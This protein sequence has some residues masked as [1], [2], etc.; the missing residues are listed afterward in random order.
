MTNK[1]RHDKERIIVRDHVSRQLVMSLSL[2]EVSRNLTYE[3]FDDKC[4]QA[5]ILYCDHKN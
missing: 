3:Q 4:I 1:I 2:S 5:Y